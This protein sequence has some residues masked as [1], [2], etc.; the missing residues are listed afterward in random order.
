MLFAEHLPRWKDE[1]P[2]EKFCQPKGV[3][4][5]EQV[6]GQDNSDILVA[7]ASSQHSHRQ[8]ALGS[9][10]TRRIIRVSPLTLA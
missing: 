3:D 8:A 7:L 5:F 2:C 4:P 10:P 9:L 6:I 1:L